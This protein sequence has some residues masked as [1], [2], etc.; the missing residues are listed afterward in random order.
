MKE[1]SEDS[2]SL[3]NSTRGLVIYSE[4]GQFDV[5]YRHGGYDLGAQSELVMSL[6][7]EVCVAVLVNMNT[8]EENEAF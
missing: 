4:I 6:G 3:V 5:Y 1:T 7:D 2:T 8:Y